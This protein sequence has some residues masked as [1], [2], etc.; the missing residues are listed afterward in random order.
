[1]ACYAARDVQ[2]VLH[3]GTL[4]ISNI[5]KKADKK[6]TIVFSGNAS[7]DELGILGEGRQMGSEIAGICAGLYLDNAPYCVPGNEHQVAI[8]VEDRMI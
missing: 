4:N 5:C 7:V 6:W 1:M 8:L 3:V 2:C